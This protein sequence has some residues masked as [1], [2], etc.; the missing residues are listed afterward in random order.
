E[1]AVLGVAFSRDGRYLASGGAD[2]AVCVWDV[3]SGARRM[4][5]RGHS[6]E[7][8]SVSFDPEGCR[9]LSFA[10]RQGMA[11]VWDLTRHPEYDT[12]GQTPAEAEAMAF[13]PDGQQ[14]LTATLGGHLQ[15][16]DAV[17][18]VLVGERRVAMT[19]RLASP[20]VVAAFDPGGRFLAGL[21][22]EDPRVV[23]VW[24]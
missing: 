19:D 6:A 16:W 22:A 17:A 9:L 3:A 1:T 24:A 18:G 11:K 14:L 20:A 13:R 12:I 5:F 8:S 10:P 23:K 21:A 15:T 2:R 7:V 4:T